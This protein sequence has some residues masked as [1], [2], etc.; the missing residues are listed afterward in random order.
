MSDVEHIV[1]CY[2]ND[3]ALCGCAL[4]ALRGDVLDCIGE[5]S[6]ALADVG[7]ARLY[8]DDLSAPGQ[9]ASAIC[10]ACARRAGLRKAGVR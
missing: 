6:V 5:Y 3:T 9:H 2:G 7:E 10:L 8:V 1:A 4:V